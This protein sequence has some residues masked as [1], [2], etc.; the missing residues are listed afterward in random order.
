MASA[1]ALP[2]PRDVAYP[3]IIA[4]NVDATD[5]DRRIFRI[6][7]KIPVVRSGPLTLL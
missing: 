5:I 4:L 6:T 2:A 7:Q 3:G 1:P